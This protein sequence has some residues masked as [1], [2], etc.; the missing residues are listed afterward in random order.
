LARAHA[1]SGDAAVIS[2]Y[3]SDESTFDEA[4]GSFAMAYADQAEKDYEEFA[5]AVR[6][7]R[8]PV[9]EDLGL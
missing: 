1:R 4:I 6:S 8:L 7:G 9:A 5:A 2:G 3:L